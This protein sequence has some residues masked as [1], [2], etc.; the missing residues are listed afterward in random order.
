MLNSIT[1]STGN[2]I[3]IPIFDAWTKKE[4]K[5][6][7]NGILRDYEPSN[8]LKYSR[9]SDSE[10]LELGNI[11]CGTN[12]SNLNIIFDHQPQ[13][14]DGHWCMVIFWA[15]NPVVSKFC[16]YHPFIVSND[17]LS[18]EAHAGQFGQSNALQPRYYNSYNAAPWHE[19]DVPS[20]TNYLDMVA[21]FNANTRNPADPRSNVRSGGYYTLDIYWYNSQ[22]TSPGSGMP[23]DAPLEASVYTK[24]ATYETLTH[25]EV[26]Y[27]EPS[28]DYTDPYGNIISQPGGGDGDPD[29]DPENI[30]K[31]FP[32]FGMLLSGKG[33]NT[34]I[35]FFIRSRRGYDNNV[36]R[37]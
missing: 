11:L 13:S 30:E 32:S 17:N 23:G 10:L 12:K 27:T 21:W 18:I 20:T 29:V 1:L 3:K 5:S 6:R 25:N 9:L 14:R 4:N 35:T 22:T 37:N 16:L 31:G 26:D 7:A 15:Y 33:H 2:T 19:S 36:L 8:L 28:G 24:I 34:C